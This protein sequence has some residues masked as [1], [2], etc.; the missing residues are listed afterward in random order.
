MKYIDEGAKWI[1]GLG[2]IGVVIYFIATNLHVSSVLAA[3]VIT[4]VGTFYLVGRIALWIKE[5]LK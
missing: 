4:Y 1:F 5:K 3:V 2:F